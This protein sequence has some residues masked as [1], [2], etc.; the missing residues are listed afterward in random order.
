MCD[1]GVFGMTA[2]PLSGMSGVLIRILGANWTVPIEKRHGQGRWLI[3]PPRGTT[4]NSSQ[5]AG[6][7]SSQGTGR[8]SIDKLFYTWLAIE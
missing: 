4:T 3:L 7:Y 6:L 5:V 8:A 2:A 1:L